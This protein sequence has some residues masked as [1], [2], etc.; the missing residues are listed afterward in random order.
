MVILS[1]K[2][3]YIPFIISA[4]INCIGAEKGD[5]SETPNDTET[6]LLD[7][8]YGVKYASA[9]E[10]KLN[11]FCNHSHIIKFNHLI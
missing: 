11:I 2:C 3:I 9:C 5:N 7:K 6:E 8:E 10:G 1:N 4:L